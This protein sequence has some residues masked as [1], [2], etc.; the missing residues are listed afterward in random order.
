MSLP[1]EI[2]S[3][4]EVQVTLDRKDLRIVHPLFGNGHIPDNP[5]KEDIEIRVLPMTSELFWTDENVMSILKWCV[6]E[7]TRVTVQVPAWPS[8][9]GTGRP[10]R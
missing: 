4:S 9:C 5:A 1:E 3:G 6:T 2:K 10:A 8:N 7:S